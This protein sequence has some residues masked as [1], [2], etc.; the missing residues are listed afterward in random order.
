L[1]SA[2]AVIVRDDLGTLA[3]VVRLSRRARRVV[4]QNLV[5]AATLIAVLVTWNVAG[6]LPLPW[7]WPGTRDRP[8]W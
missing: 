2:D 1:S 4:A 5:I 7:V 6:D 8:S 3:V